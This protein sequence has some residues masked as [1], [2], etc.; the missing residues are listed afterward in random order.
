MDPTLNI[1][2]PMQADTALDIDVQSEY[3]FMSFDGPAN[4]LICRI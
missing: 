4:V 3:P 1:D 2:G